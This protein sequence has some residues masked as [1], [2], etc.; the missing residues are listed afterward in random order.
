MTFGN[1]HNSCLF[2]PSFYH[3]KNVEGWRNKPFPLHERLAYIFGKD[4]ATE[5]GA[6]T[7]VDMIENEN[8]N[9]LETEFKIGEGLSPTSTDQ[10]QTKSSKRKMATSTDLLVGSLEN[11]AYIFQDVMEKS[12]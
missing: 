8:E 7:L 1:W 3:H 11:F 9:I 6:E 10:G 2:F 5:K 12:N 4:G